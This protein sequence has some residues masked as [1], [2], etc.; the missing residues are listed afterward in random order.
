MFLSEKQLKSR[1]ESLAPQRSSLNESEKWDWSAGGLAEADI[2]LVIT[3]VKTVV[4][5]MA[6]TLA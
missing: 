6:K 5:T 2:V 4:K 3:L 1:H